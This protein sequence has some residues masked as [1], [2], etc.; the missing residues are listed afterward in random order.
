[1][2]LDG[3]TCLITGANRGIGLAIAERLA[4]EP[5]RLLVGVRELSRYES[6]KAPQGGASEIRPVRM[7]LSSR[8][9]IDACLH[10][11]GGELETIDVLINNAGEFTAGQLE[12]QDLGLIYAMVQANLLG[13]I[14]LSHQVLPGMLAR[15]HGKIVNQASVVGHMFYPG[16]STYSATKAGLIA[17]SECLARELHDTNVS[18]LE[19][20]TGGV[21]TD[22]LDV[23]REE[24]DQHLDTSGF[25]QYEPQEWAEKVVA[26]I[27]SDDNVVGPGGKVALGKL[28]SH[29]PRWLLDGLA[30]ASFD[31]T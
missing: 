27:E 28:A 1:M 2:D 9:S 8:E 31:R 19:L 24:L 6:I 7:E 22:M 21:D 16:V 4:E 18:V 17:F 23:A 30:G 3:A 5:V 26:A 13:P 14:H 25:V 20:I 10:E 12:R 29:G 15:D 11:L